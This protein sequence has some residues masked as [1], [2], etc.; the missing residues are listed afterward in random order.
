[1]E[2]KKKW[3]ESK[4][5]HMTLNKPNDFFRQECLYMQGDL[6]SIHNFPYSHSL[7]SHADLIIQIHARG[8]IGVIHR[9]PPQTTIRV[10]RIFLLMIHRRTVL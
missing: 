5:F 2:K 3:K 7:S 8:S 10:A 9:G 6:A 1:M 4:P